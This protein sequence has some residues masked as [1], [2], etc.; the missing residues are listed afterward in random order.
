M[1]AC[2]EG[3]S[4]VLRYI[5]K[6][7][8]GSQPI[9]AKASDGEFYVVKFM[10]NLQGPNLLFNEAMGTE[11]YKMC[12][13][14]VP[15]WKPLLVPEAFIDENRACWIEGAKGLLRPEAGICFGSHYLGSNGR[16][17]YEILPGT[18]FARV[19]NRAGF[20]LAWL[21]DICAG[22][23]DNRQGIFEE[24]ADGHLTAYFIDHGHMFSGPTGDQRPRVVAS[25]Y[26]DPR[27]YSGT[28]PGFLLALPKVIDKLNVEQLW[29][30]A[31]MLP[32][33]WRC[34]SA[35]RNFSQ[36]LARLSNS[37]FLQTAL[38]GMMESYSRAC[39]HGKSVPQSDRILPFSVLCPGLPQAGRL[40]KTVA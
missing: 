38:D 37:R 34:D 29:D 39:D 3:L 19:L 35:V 8:G 12:G 15:H 30:K 25:R 10:N 24:G 7:R 9:L 31:Q 21:V 2:E 14:P 32:R 17:L 28:P 22:H 18:Y 40:G 16:K 11:L 36:A 23:T 26:M 20:W 4:V 13:L 1:S 33:E 27:V 6:L 5:R